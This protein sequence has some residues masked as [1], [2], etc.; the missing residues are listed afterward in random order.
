[1]EHLSI[2]FMKSFLTPMLAIVLLGAVLG[3]AGNH[4]SPRGIPLLTPPKKIPKAEEFIALDKARELWGNGAALFI[5]AREP[6]DYSAGHIGNALN[7]PALSFEQHFGAIVPML[8][9]ESQI[10]IYCDGQ[11]CDLSHRLAE[12]LRQQGF[13]NSHILFNGWTAWRQAGLPTT[14]GGQK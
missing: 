14:S 3:L 2:C 8:T 13:T 7:L 5:D 12:S 11:E 6:A 10:V 4:L 1:M 9:P